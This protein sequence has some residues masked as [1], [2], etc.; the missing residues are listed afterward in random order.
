MNL[1][2]QH[3]RL[4]RVTGC[5]CYISLSVVFSRKFGSKGAGVRASLVCD[6]G[7]VW[8]SFFKESSY[9]FLGVVSLPFLSSP[10]QP[11]DQQDHF[12]F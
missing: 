9:S 1:S 6:Y 7:L 4:C 12:S 11:S 8:Y 10:S 5:S 2:L 3:M